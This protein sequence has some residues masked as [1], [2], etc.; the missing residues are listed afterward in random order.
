M[1]VAVAETGGGESAW[2]LLR[3]LRRAASECMSGMSSYELPSSSFAHR[4]IQ[5]AC[6]HFKLSEQHVGM[7]K[8][9]VEFAPGKPFGL[10][11]GGDDDEP[12]HPSSPPPPLSNPIFIF[13]LP[14]T[15]CL[16]A[17]KDGD[18]DGH[19]QLLGVPGT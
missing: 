6:R 5:A 9:T 15:V 19:V 8:T 4:L 7:T 17:R 1:D 3:G 14:L 10:R 13:P 11:R 12:L 2:Q 16:L 18:Q